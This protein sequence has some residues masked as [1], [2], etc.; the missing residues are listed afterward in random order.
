M[1]HKINKTSVAA[2]GSEVF[3]FS[4]GQMNGLVIYSDNDTVT[5]AQLFVT[6]RFRG[7]DADH[8]AINRVSLSALNTISA[9]ELGLDAGVSGDNF[10]GIDFGNVDLDETECEVIVENTNGSTACAVG[11]YVID[12]DNDTDHV[13]VYEQFADKNSS[14]DDVEAI[15]LAGLASGNTVIVRQG[16]NAWS[17][18]Y[19]GLLGE[20]VVMGHL[21]YAAS[22]PAV[23]KAYQSYD[24]IPDTVNINVVTSESGYYGIVKR[25]IVHPNRVQKSSV[26]AAHKL[27]GRLERIALRNP[28]KVTALNRAGVVPL[29]ADLRAAAG[30]AGSKFLG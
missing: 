14:F 19:H 1:N 3:N 12:T 22:L 21:N 20:S 11:V 15:Y 27:A 2:S 5:L 30:K 29:P 28:Q 4:S 25:R 17:T 8:P 23:L 26:K 18:D 10:T 7:G 24:G 16:E 9:I 13:F 6:V